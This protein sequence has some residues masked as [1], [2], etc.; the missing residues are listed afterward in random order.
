MQRKFHYDLWGIPL[1]IVGWRLA[2]LSLD[3]PQ[4]F[5]SMDLQKAIKDRQ[6]THVA[7]ASRLSLNMNTRGPRICLTPAHCFTCI[8]QGLTHLN[9]PYHILLYTANRRM[10]LY[11]QKLPS[12]RTSPETL[13]DHIFIYC[14]IFRGT[15]NFPFPPSQIM[16][17]TLLC[18]TS[19]CMTNGFCGTLTASYLIPSP[20]MLVCI[21]ST[22]SSD[23]W[24]DSPSLWQP[25]G[26]DWWWCLQSRSLMAYVLGGW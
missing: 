14:T 12:T 11:G 3:P 10:L 2:P 5:K 25:V 7:G 26:M 13:P 24:Q 4:L 18:R 15:K 16:N 19:M 22:P 21:A 1:S 20:L 9:A 8:C 23:C 6:N 17:I